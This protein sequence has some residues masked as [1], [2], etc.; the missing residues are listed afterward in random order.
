MIDS[1]KDLSLPS[2]N[3]DDRT[4]KYVN[5]I[6]SV[7][8]PIAL[9]WL[10]YSLSQG[11]TCSR[12]TCW[13]VIVGIAVAYL[14]QRFLSAEEPTVMALLGGARSAVTSV[15]DSVRTRLLKNDA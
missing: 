1:I 5:R 4:K 6:L 7:A 14:V 11:Q 10:I 9:G 2:I 3:I 13:R 15:V 8:I 12:K